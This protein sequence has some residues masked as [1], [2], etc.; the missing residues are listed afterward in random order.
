M[1]N[2]DL[3]QL[4]QQTKKLSAMVVED[5][6][7]TNELLSSTLKTFFGEVRS[8]LNA[9]DALEVYPSYIPDVLFVDIMMGKMDGI[10]LSKKI[11][12]QKP[13]QI[14]I[15]ISASNDMKKISESIE[16]GVNSFIQKPID[17]KKIIDL[18]GTIVAL[19][20]KKKKVEI[21]TFSISLPM[22]LYEIVD[23]SAKS[24][25]ISKN[26]IIIRAL[27]DFYGND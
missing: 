18:L 27:R 5:E 11:R 14:I 24:E 4:T 25:S 3:V 2:I 1:T 10:E 12:K 26:A 15:V 8:F 13:D 20:E 22:D 9:E 23:G 6:K 16:V 17:T 21:K 7:V 19:I